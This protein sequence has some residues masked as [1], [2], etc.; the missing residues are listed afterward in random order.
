MVGRS[1]CRSLPF[2]MPALVVPLIA[3]RL[4]ASGDKLRRDRD[5]GSATSRRMSSSTTSSSCCPD[6][7]RP[8]ADLLAS[9]PAL[10]IVATSREPLRIAGEV[11]FDLPPMGEPDAVD[12]VPRA[13]ARRSAPTSLTLPRCTS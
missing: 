2:A 7:A 1:S 4:G 11:E 8:L 13:G 10:R 3:E 5:R 12:A 9:A 6:A